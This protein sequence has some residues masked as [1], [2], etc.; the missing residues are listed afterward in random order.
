MRAKRPRLFS[1]FRT[2]CDFVSVI[3][4]KHNCSSNTD[5]AW[6]NLSFSFNQKEDNCC[7]FLRSNA[8]VPLA[9]N[10]MVVIVPKELLCYFIYSS[11]YIH[12]SFFYHF[13][14]VSRSFPSPYDWF[15]TEIAP[16]DHSLLILS[17]SFPAS[18]SQENSN[19]TCHLFG[20]LSAP[21][22]S[23][24]VLEKCLHQG[25]KEGLIKRRMK[26]VISRREDCWTHQ[27]HARQ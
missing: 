10:E 27:W 1:Y 23:L 17:H 18:A 11:T 6:L 16:E 24:F 19:Y 9:Q 22:H 8:A 3:C 13:I 21:C 25:K 7:I 2:T 5:G 20:S 14:S 15:V 26:K 12:K 4:M